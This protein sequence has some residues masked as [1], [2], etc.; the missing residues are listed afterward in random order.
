[1]AEAMISQPQ[2]VSRA[3]EAQG[4]LVRV[5]DVHKVYTRQRAD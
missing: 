5:Q 2:E 3:G 1:M 4:A